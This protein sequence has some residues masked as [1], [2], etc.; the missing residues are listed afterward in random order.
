AQGTPARHPPP[1]R[2]AA[3]AARAPRRAARAARAPHVLAAPLARVEPHLLKVRQPDTRLHA[4]LPAPHAHRML[5]AVLAAPLARVEPHL[6]KVRQPDTRLHAALPAPHAHRMLRAVLAAPLA[7]VEPH[8][9]KAILDEACSAPVLCVCGDSVQLAART[10]AVLL[11]P[12]LLVLLA[13]SWRHFETG[14]VHSPFTQYL[15]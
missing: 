8:L 2:R 14:Q 1:A 6:L 5:R 10:D 15:Y 13:D 11:Q 12:D 4:A 7:R 9:L 3:R